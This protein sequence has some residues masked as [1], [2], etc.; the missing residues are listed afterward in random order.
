MVV[1]LIALFV[2]LGGGAYAAFKLPKNSVGTKQIKRH[3][4]TPPKLSKKTIKQLAGKQG[5]PGLPGAAGEPGAPGPGAKLLALD[6]PPGAATYTALGPAGAYT[7]LVRC[8][9]ASTN[10]TADLAVAGPAGAVEETRKVSANVE[11]FSE[12]LPAI[13]ADSPVPLASMT[14]SATGNPLGIGWNSVRLSSGGQTVDVE[15]WTRASAPG[16]GRTA[17][18]HYSASVTQVQ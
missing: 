13:A 18:C 15:A 2:A 9:A 3:A 5:P 8:T 1:A 14:G 17:G 16:G 12:S 7:L 10:V 6:V 4:V 11:V